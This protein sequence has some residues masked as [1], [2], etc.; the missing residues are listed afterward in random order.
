M[1]LAGFLQGDHHHGFDQGLTSYVQEYIWRLLKTHL[2]AISALYP[3]ILIELDLTI[4]FHSVRITG[5]SFDARSGI[6]A[7]YLPLDINIT[8]EAGFKPSN[9]ITV[10]VDG[11]RKV[12]V[13]EHTKDRTKRCTTNPN[14]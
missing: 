5:T 2:W 3:H 8:F 11:D 7:N 1:R 9:D 6:S 4:L 10:L 12:A 13:L 14:M